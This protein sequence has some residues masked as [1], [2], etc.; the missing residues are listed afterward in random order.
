MGLGVAIAAAVTFGWASSAANVAPVL[1]GEPEQQAAFEQ[2]ARAT[3]FDRAPDLGIQWA[4]E[5]C[6]DGDSTPSAAV[7]PS[8]KMR[9]LALCVAPIRPQNAHRRGT[10]AGATYPSRWLRAAAAPTAY[11]TVP[12]A[13]AGGMRAETATASAKARDVIF[14]SWVLLR[15]IARARHLRSVRPPLPTPAAD[16]FEARLPCLRRR[17]PARTL[18]VRITNLA[19]WYV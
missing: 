11:F 15:D 19:E 10:P 13:L 8:E 4:L 12:A 3:T 16:R 5:P 6:S 2:G 9:Y 18:P 7:P 14:L 17:G 1:P